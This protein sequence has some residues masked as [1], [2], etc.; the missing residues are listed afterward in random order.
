MA[1]MS[2]TERE[3]DEINANAGENQ[4]AAEGSAEEGNGAGADQ[5]QDQAFD[6]TAESAEEVKTSTSIA[7][8]VKQS[9]WPASGV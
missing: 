6:L 3:T 9:W 7:T 4:E 8:P 1:A 5:G 2:F